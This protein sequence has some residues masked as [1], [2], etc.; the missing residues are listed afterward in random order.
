MMMMMMMMMMKG[1]EKLFCNS[2]WKWE[3]TMRNVHLGRRRRQ[4]S[5]GRGGGRLTVIRIGTC[6]TEPIPVAAR[7]KAAAL[8]CRDCGFESRKQHGRLSLLS[9]M[10]CHAEVSATGRSLVQRSPNECG[11]SAISKPQ[12]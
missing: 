7:Y 4:K 12:R 8:A 11:V 6:G 9:A 3:D 2:R 1:L 5:V 10:C